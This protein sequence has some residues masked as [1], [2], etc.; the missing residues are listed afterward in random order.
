ML[1]L[2]SFLN[3][4]L[5]CPEFYGSDL[6]LIKIMTVQLVYIQGSVGIPFPPPA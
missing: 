5:A 6:I 1:Y 2:L 3:V 4:L